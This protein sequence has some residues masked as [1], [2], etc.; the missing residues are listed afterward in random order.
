[1]DHP[2]H[3]L[4]AWALPD[5]LRCW[6]GPDMCDGP[7]QDPRVLRRRGL[8]TVLCGPSMTNLEQGM[9]ECRQ[10][11]YIVGF[12]RGLLLP[13]TVAAPLCTFVTLMTTTKDTA[14]HA[15]LK[16][17]TKLPG[18][19]TLVVVECDG[20]RVVSRQLSESEH[21]TQPWGLSLACPGCL[22]FGYLL[23]MPHRDGNAAARR[24]RFR[25][26][27]FK[28]AFYI[29]ELYIETPPFVRWEHD[30]L[31]SYKYPLTREQETYLSKRF[32]EY[33]NSQEGAMVYAGWLKTQR[34]MFFE[35]RVG[36]VRGKEEVGTYDDGEF[37]ESDGAFGEKVSGVRRYFN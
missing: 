37:S 3:G 24:S 33:Q 18:G 35:E 23:A 34:G 32:E 20:D 12:G 22:S 21:P 10:F 26:K 6:V 31:F 29:P 16:A 7:L 25:F 4:Q 1:M 15:A 11:D 2:I 8:I 27:C 17:F 36:R 13:V 19:V 9:V 28:C 5:L 30:L 14:W